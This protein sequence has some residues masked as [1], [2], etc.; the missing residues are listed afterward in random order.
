L[1]ARY[2]NRLG[3]RAASLLNSLEGRLDRLM[4]AWILLA[5]LACALRIASSP[6]RGPVDLGTIAPYVLLVLAPFASMVLAM[7]WFQQGDRIAQPKIRLAVV[8]RWRNLDLAQ[9]RAHPLYGAG[10]IMVSL[11]IG[12][13]LNVPMRALEYLAAMPALVGP[14]PSWLSTLSFL[15]TFDVVVFTSL[16]VV[17]FVA[18]LRRVSLFPRL[19]GAIWI[20]DLTMQALT[21]H[22]LANATSVP[23]GVENALDA[24]LDG[25]MQKVLISAG[26]WLPYLL[27]SRRV[28]VTYRHRIAD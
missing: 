7:R 15:M 5:G 17:A 14:I 4:Q 2:Q 10:G 16:Y 18:A 12:I 23:A 26:V 9:A 25:N 27:F 8:G 13:L 11:L 24:L 22:M 19:L 1:F 6:I 21:A 3:T 28:N 20:F